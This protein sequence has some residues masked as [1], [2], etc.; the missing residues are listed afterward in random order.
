MSEAMGVSKKPCLNVSVIPT[1]FEKPA[2]LKRKMPAVESQLQKRKDPFMIL[3]VS[4]SLALGCFSMLNINVVT[5]HSLILQSVSP[6]HK[7]SDSMG[8]S[9]KDSI[10]MVFGNHQPLC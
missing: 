6:P 4:K 3:N 10:Q 7:L 2:L 1:L 9:S 8:V 5:D